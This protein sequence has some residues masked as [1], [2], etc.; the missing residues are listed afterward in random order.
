MIADHY[1]KKA[2]KYK[3]GPSSENVWDLRIEPVTDAFQGD[4]GALEKEMRI[5]EQQEEEERR[6]KTTVKMCGDGVSGI[7]N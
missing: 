3:T 1:R 6:R 5:A 7:A 2:I 4:F